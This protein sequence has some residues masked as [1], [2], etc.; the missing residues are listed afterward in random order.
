MK[1]A[2]TL[3]GYTTPI[4]SG[5][6]SGVPTGGLF[7]NGQVGGTGTSIIQT[8]IILVIILATIFA[9]W[10]ILKG[11]WDMAT[12][13]GLKEQFKR[14]RDRVEY[15]LFGIFLVFVAF[16]LLGIA[17]ALFGTNLLPFLYNFAKP[18]PTP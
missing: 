10:S 14:G 17:G 2:L 9:L 1:I 6:P 13:R 3:P 18:S 5:L 12:S 15:T 16:I 7:T 8:L 11:G 4:D